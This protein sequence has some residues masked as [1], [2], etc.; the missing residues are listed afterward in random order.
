M[1]TPSWKDTVIVSLF[2]SRILAISYEEHS[3]IRVEIAPLNSRDFLL[4]HCGCDREANYSAHWDLLS[5]VRFEPSNQTIKLILG[6]TAIAFV[7]L[8]DESKA[9]ERYSRQI[10]RLSRYDHTVH[11]RR[12]RQNCPDVS[13]VDSDRDRSRSLERALFAKFDE[14]LPVKF[15]KPKVT[16]SLVKED[17]TSGLRTP[18]VL[19]YFLKIVAMEGDQLSEEP[20]ITCSTSD[21]GLLAINPS[22]NVER[23]LLCVVAPKEGFIDIFPFS[24]DLGPPRARL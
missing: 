12:V 7:A 19:T 20:G 6:R 13:E 2:P 3:T 1:T 8:S 4:A 14:T 22:F 17:E 15:D 9:A 21:R 23:P 18:N 11:S 16:Q 24:S 10:D 5:F